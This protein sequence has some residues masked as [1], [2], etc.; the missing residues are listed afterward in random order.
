[1]RACVCVCVCVCECVCVRVRAR[2]RMHV[3]VSGRE[4][5][6]NT[7]PPRSHMRTEHF[8][9]SSLPILRPTVGCTCSDAQPPTVHTSQNSPCLCVRAPAHGCSRAHCP[10]CT[11]FASVCTQARRACR[12]VCVPCEQ[13]ETSAC[14]G[15]HL[16]EHEVEV[17]RRRLGARVHVFDAL[18]QRAFTSFVQPY[19]QQM[20]LPFL[21]D[22]DTVHTQACGAGTNVSSAA[23]TAAIPAL[24]HFAHG[25][26]A[27]Q[28]GHTHPSSCG[29]WSGR[30]HSRA[31]TSRALP[32][33]VCLAQTQSLPASAKK[34]SSPCRLVTA[35]M[36]TSNRSSTSTDHE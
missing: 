23:A 3:C 22:N 6:I 4:C 9:M 33:A 31:S 20:E 14:A 18:E 27:P 24:R 12:P 8:L 21:C 2:M 26:S 28:G 19:Q 30:A 34:K 10:C 7:C 16:A 32:V 11:R 36:I 17:M 15:A 5:S 35:A 29:R 1:M 13:A 25:S